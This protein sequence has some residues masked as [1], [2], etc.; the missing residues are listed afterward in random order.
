MKKETQVKTGASTNQPTPAPKVNSGDRQF[1][2]FVHQALQ[3]V[4]K[5]KK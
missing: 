4:F 3:A 5:P 1:D 2:Q